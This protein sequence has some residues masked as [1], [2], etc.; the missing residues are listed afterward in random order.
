MKEQPKDW[1]T[2][3]LGILKLENTLVHLTEFGGPASVAPRPFRLAI[4]R[5]QFALAR[6]AVMAHS[7]AEQEAL[8][9]RK[10]MLAE[11]RKKGIPELPGRLPARL[12]PT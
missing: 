1:E 10:R 9:S 8:V 3:R 12:R 4:R 11:Q 5:A 7:L 2:I 6:A